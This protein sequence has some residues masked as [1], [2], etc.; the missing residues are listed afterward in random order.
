MLVKFPDRLI[1]PCTNDS[2]TAPYGFKNHMALSPDST[3]FAVSFCCCYLCILLCVCKFCVPRTGS[4][5]CDS[6][7]RQYRQSRRRL[8][9]N[10]AGNCLWRSN[11]LARQ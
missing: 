6:N 5:G 10:R 2:C 3:K 11:R 7:V 9:R 8:G 4:C 1:N